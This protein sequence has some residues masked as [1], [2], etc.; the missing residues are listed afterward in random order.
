[1]QN[2]KAKS[3]DLASVYY[4]LSFTERLHELLT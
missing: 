2:K 3:N 1:M 4:N